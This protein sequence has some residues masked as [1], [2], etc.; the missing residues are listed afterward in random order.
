LPPGPLRIMTFGKFGTY[1]K[2]ET[3][4]EAYKLL[5][6]KHAS[7]ELVIAGTDNPNAEG[8]LQAVK[9]KYADLAGIHFTGY[10]A[11]QDVPTLFHDSAVV[12]FPYTSTT[13]SSGVLHQAGSYSRA[14]VL[15]ELGDLAELIREEGYTGEFFEPENP[16]N[17][18]AAIAR[19]LDTDEYRVEMGRQNYLAATGLPISEVTDWYLLHFEELLAKR[20]RPKRGQVGSQ[21][22]YTTQAYSPNRL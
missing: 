21:Q 8:Y 7:L 5:L 12:V 1:K 3:L 2:V 18:A 4:I 9:E 22:L 6:A 19:L 13:G 14:V 11:E 16:A 20:G 17:L 15:P 10:V